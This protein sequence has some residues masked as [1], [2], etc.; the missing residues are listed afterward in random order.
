MY[1]GN[2]SIADLD[3]LIRGNDVGACR[4][5]NH[6]TDSIRHNKHFTRLLQGL[7]TF[8]LLEQFFFL[9]TDLHIE[10]LEGL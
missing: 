4:L 5:S 6:L 10:R 7:A 2:H 9:Y 8:G 3:D 1:R